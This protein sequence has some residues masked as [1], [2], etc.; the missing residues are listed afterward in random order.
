MSAP[1]YYFW[2]LSVICK[3]YLN[4]KCQSE[5]ELDY[6]KWQVILIKITN[7]KYIN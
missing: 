2:L 4:Y 3:T 6:K 5:S 7:Q 1:V